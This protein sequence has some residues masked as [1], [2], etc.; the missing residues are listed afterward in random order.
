MAGRPYREKAEMTS[1]Q[2]NYLDVNE[3]TKSVT[4]ESGEVLLIAGPNGVGK[5]ALLESLYR[6]MPPQTARYIPGHRQIY[7]NE[8]WETARSDLRHLLEAIYG[9]V[10][11][12]TRY[13]DHQAEDQFRLIIKSFV[14]QSSFAAHQTVEEMKSSGQ[15]QGNLTHRTSLYDKLNNVFELAN[16][17]VRF[18]P[19]L[20]RGICA[21]R[22][23]MQYD[24]EALSDGERAALYISAAFITQ[25]PNTILFI[26]E[27]EKH[28][29]PSISETLIRAALRIRNDLAVVVATHDVYLIQAMGASKFIH[30]KDSVVKS[31]KPERRVFDAQ[32]IEGMDT[33]SDD[34]RRDI[35]GA[36]STLLFVEG[37]ESSDDKSLYRHIYKGIQV[38]PKGSCEQVIEAVRALKDLG[39]AHWIE[40][41]GIIDGDGRS[42]QEKKSLETKG[43]YSLPVPSIENVFLLTA[44]I[45]CYISA[46][47]N[48]K[49]G[50]SYDDRIT[51]LQHVVINEVQAEVSNIAHKL[52]CWRISRRLISEIP[53]V[54]SLQQGNVSDISV[55]VGQIVDEANNEVT[56]IVSSGDWKVILSELP[57][58]STQLG[59]KCARALGAKNFDDY[60][61]TILYQLDNRT[62]AGVRLQNELQRLL[63]K[64]AGTVTAEASSV[65]ELDARRRPTT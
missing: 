44:S 43:V 59:Q 45:E 37:I 34:L 20:D 21:V 58:K 10:A 12:T 49:P 29:H 52:A 8:S 18:A 46:S 30:I 1:H 47:L 50:K 9:G 19:S 57:L 42:Q 3:N 13:R 14:D 2:L 48:F 64:I 6:S 28:L 62:A 7:F 15:G 55:P 5:S 65:V 41:Y 61:K 22:G 60:K 11:N 23:N 26:D 35:L 17:A 63:P 4:V 32:L 27:P 36:R 33:I 40:P 38:A 16:M 53:S 25:R 39:N 31:T 56:R 24:I 54:A 51:L